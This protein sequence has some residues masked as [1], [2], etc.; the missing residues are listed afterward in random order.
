MYFRLIS[1]QGRGCSGR[2]TGTCPTIIPRRAPAGGLA[3]QLALE[4]AGSL[5][6]QK[7][8]EALVTLDPLAFF[9][10]IKFDPEG[11]IVYGARW[12]G[13]GKPGS[14]GVLH[15]SII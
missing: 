11:L 14:S 15:H 13:S 8:R 3:L 6:P 2:S 1:C 4:K 9:G 12:D 10:R 7:V 5:D